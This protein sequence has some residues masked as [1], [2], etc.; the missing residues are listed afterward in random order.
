M[1][2]IWLDLQIYIFICLY[3]YVFLFKNIY[4]LHMK[5]KIYKFSNVH[6]EFFN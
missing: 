4:L 5:M 2:Y 6:Y 3:I 1:C